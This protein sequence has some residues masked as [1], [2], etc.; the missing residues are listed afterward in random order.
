MIRINPKKFMIASAV[1]AAFLIAGPASAFDAAGQQIT[2]QT[3]EAF[4]VAKNV[5][6]TAAVLALIIG[7]A[8][9]LWGQVKVKWII[10]SLVACVVFGLVPTVVAAF[11]GTG[12]ACS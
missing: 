2:A 10:S 9:M 5:L 11:A 12:A 7:L 3:C 8:P 4:K 1:G 6:L